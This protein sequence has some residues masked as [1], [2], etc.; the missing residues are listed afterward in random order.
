MYEMMHQ[1]KSEDQINHKE[2]I[3][4]KEFIGY[5]QDYKEIEERNRKNKQIVVAK[6]NLMKKEDE[7]VTDE[8]DQVQEEI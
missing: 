6:Q 3:T 7:D 5:F 8:V 1:P 4:W 2:F